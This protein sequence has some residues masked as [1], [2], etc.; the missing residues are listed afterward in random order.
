[1][2]HVAV[3][4]GA[5]HLDMFVLPWTKHHSATHC[6]TMISNTRPVSVGLSLGLLDP[7]L[8]KH[9]SIFIYVT[10]FFNIHLTKF[11]TNPILLLQP[12]SP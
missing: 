10:K 5:Q 8:L 12:P 11:F 3:V 6:Y 1:M 4:C 7:Y 2:L 9:S